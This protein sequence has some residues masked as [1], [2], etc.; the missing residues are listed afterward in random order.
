MPDGS[1][2]GSSNN[3]GAPQMSNPQ[4]GSQFNGGAASLS[5]AEQAQGAYNLGNYNFGQ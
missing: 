2:A 5:G 3:F 4:M 1:V